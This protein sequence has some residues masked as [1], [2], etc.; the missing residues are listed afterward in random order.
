MSRIQTEHETAANRLV[1]EMEGAWGD[2]RE[3]LARHAEKTG[4]A[5]ASQLKV[6]T[7]EDLRRLLTERGGL[8]L[9][10]ATAYERQ[11]PILRALE[12]LSEYEAAARDLS[13]GG[14]NADG[15]HGLAYWLASESLDRAK[16]DG[17]FQLCLA[18][19]ALHILYPAMSR[20]RRLKTF[21]R[22]DEGALRQLQQDLAYWRKDAEAQIKD[23]DEIVRR[24]R[25]WAERAAAKLPEVLRLGGD[26]ASEDQMQHM[27]ET[28]QRH[29]V[30]W[31]RQQRA[32]QGSF[33]FLKLL[34]EQGGL[35]T[36]EAA[37][38]LVE[39]Q[40]EKRLMQQERDAAIQWLKSWAPGE[41]ADGFPLPQME[42]QPAEETV[43][44]L[45]RRMFLSAGTEWTESIEIVRPRTPLEGPRNRWR[46]FQAV[47]V[48]EQV[49]DKA[50]QPILRRGIGKIVAA[51]V[52]ALREI[53]RARDVVVYG[54]AAAQEEE[55]KGIALAEEAAR[56]ALLLLEQGTTTEGEEDRAI[57]RCLVMAQL[58]FLS[59]CAYEFERRRMGALGLVTR[60][61][62][63]QF[64][65]DVKGLVAGT[66]RQVTGRMQEGSGRAWKRLVLLSGLSPPI[67]VSV[68]PVHRRLSLSDALE[69][70][71]KD[72]AL[73]ALYKRLF[74]LAPVENERFL[75]GREREMSALAEALTDWKA[76]R[77]GAVLV[78]GARGSGKT[79]LL[80][81]AMTGIFRGEECVISSFSQRV[82]DPDQ[83]LRELRR[84]TGV[85]EETDVLVALKAKR[86]IVMIEEL[87]RTFL[88]T[89]GGFG[90]L[91]MLREIV[92][93]TSSTTLWIF[94]INEIAFRYLDSIMGL[95]RHFS[96]RIDTMAVS[97]ETIAN[98]IYYRH[99]LSGLRLEFAPLLPGDPRLSGLREFLGLE[100]DPEQLF[101][102]SLYEQSE[103]IFR[104]ALEL[105]QALIERVEGGIVFM[106]QPVEPKF[107]LLDTELDLSDRFLLQAILQH[108]SLTPEEAASVLAM[109]IKECEGRTERLQF[110]ELV[111]PDPLYPGLRV[112]PEAGRF[113]RRALYR[114][115]L[116][117]GVKR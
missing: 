21:A 20:L 63:E 17:R 39:F 51:R 47:A 33:A 55:G 25:A 64:W 3:I 15:A 46:R 65:M 90:S 94:S 8:L 56:N 11:K 110:L 83:M 82:T 93:S 34:L 30:H 12:A 60:E 45:V 72:R 113:V 10:T 116:L 42:L 71:L 36:Q 114:S 14:S 75:I 48:I 73:P 9:A 117:I 40:Q 6:E 95:G 67:E 29:M 77:G 38:V 54:C 52:A 84:M 70:R 2:L 41:A 5:E 66:I 43:R 35:A 53:D 50:V 101:L 18:R 103:G 59:T 28:A 96:H 57:E 106:R 7:L 1:H 97:R 4:A 91:H 19:A 78:L 108:G 87:E 105:W 92:Y 22:S 85:P 80:R 104:S 24:Y 62:G 49:V 76:G 98:A 100:R 74:R 13:E 61:Q 26:G 44:Q 111:E 31:A 102:D 23:G 99:N 58:T 68:E 37:R 81:C 109:P 107:K 112:R 89:P 79:S 115:N 88:R 27:A 16:L 86:R 69:V 32:V